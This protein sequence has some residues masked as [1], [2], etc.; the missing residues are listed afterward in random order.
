M[1]TAPVLFLVLH[2]FSAPPNAVAGKGVLAYVGDTVILNGTG[3]NDPDGATLSYQWAQTSGPPVAL[4]GAV[5]A[6][7]R[8]VVDLP[9]TLRFQLI[10]GDGTEFS[11]PDTVA[12]VIPDTEARPLGD[13]ATGCATG[14]GNGFGL[15]AAFLGLGFLRRGPR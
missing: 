7:P 14:S 15:A 13:E 1:L 6:E 12:V 10:V 4:E 8:F 9:G 11:A 2:A 5:S 3:S